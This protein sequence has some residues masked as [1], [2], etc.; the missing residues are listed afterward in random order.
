MGE[1]AEAT[2]RREIAEEL[3][4]AV[5]VGPQI[6]SYVFEVLPGRDVRI[7]TY[8]CSLAGA[9]APRV[10]EEH[11]EWRVFP[12]DQLPSTGLPDG[13]RRSIETWRRYREHAS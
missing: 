1:T 6:D 13:Y 5:T 4:I 12:L 9:F 11:I 7:V 10:S 8:G 2:V 3:S